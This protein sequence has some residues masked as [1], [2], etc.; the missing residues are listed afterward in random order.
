MPYAL[1]P[2]LETSPGRELDCTI[3]VQNN[4]VVDQMVTFTAVTGTDMQAWFPERAGHDGPHR[5]TSDRM[6]FKLKYVGTGRVPQVV[7]VT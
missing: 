5:A 7:K 1:Y 3:V 4:Q 2:V 6:T